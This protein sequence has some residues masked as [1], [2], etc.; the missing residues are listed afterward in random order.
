MSAVVNRHQCC[1]SCRAPAVEF[2]A[3]LHMFRRG[4]WNA[5]QKQADAQVGKIKALTACR[6]FW[7]C[8]IGFL[9]PDMSCLF[10]VYFIRFFFPFF[11]KT[12]GCVPRCGNYTICFL[13][14]VPLL[15]VTVIPGFNVLVDLVVTVLH[16]FGCI[17]IDLDRMIVQDQ[18]VL[19]VRSTETHIC[20]KGA[21]NLQHHLPAR[22]T[23]CKSWFCLW[24]GCEHVFGNG[25]DFFHFL[26]D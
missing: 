3:Q 22:G 9:L 26:S 8:A 12:P 18:S 19:L 7:T 15:V 20:K 24:W 1:S 6:L 21:V 13:T 11:G 17:W 16:L 10:K 2:F 23:T 5:K 25:S 14:F 4:K